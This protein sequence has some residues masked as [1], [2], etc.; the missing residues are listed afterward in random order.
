MVREFQDRDAAAAAALI[1]EHSS[2]FATPA[3]LCHRL[4]SLPSRARA[5]RWVEER[6]GAVVGWCE[7]EFEWTTEAEDLAGLWAIVHP[8]HR[9]GGVGSALFESGVDH[10]LAHG[11]RTLRSWSDEERSPF[12]E[13]RGFEPTRNERMSALDPRTTDTSRLDVLRTALGDDGVRLVPLADLL[14]RL[15]EV[16]AL[17]V[18]A[19]ADMP[20]DNAQTNIP[21]EDWLEEKIADPD[22]SRDGSFVVLVDGR[23]ASLSWI[24]VDLERRVAGHDLT[25][26]APAYRRRGLARLAKLGVLRWC[27][28]QGIVRLLTG[29]DSENAAMLAL[30]DELGFKPYVTVTEWRKLLR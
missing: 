18:E 5:A 29:N 26:T 24:S 14:E 21:Y 13:R 2:W 6:D 8:E 27:A 19:A 3:G 23:P 15:E 9:R 25:G 12:L 17:Y 16:H 10:A 11:A 4:R 22:L 30:N 7:T 28:E 1:A 20:S